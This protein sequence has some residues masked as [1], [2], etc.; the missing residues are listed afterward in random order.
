MA[1]PMVPVGIVAECVAIKSGLI[2]IVQAVKILRC[3]LVVSELF[4]ADLIVSE[5]V[6][7]E[8][9]FQV[10]MRLE[11]VVSVCETVIGKVAGIADCMIV[12]KVVAGETIS[13]DGMAR[14]SMCAKSVSGETVRAKGVTHMDRNMG[15]EAM[16]AVEA[17]PA[18]RRMKAPAKSMKPPA[19]TK[20]MKAAAPSPKSMKPA[21]AAKSVAT[22][23]NCIN[24]RRDA[25][26]ADRN[27]RR[28]NTYC[29]IA[30]LL[31]ARSS[32]IVVRPLVS[33]VRQLPE[34]Y[35]L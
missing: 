10:V 2:E 31:I 16:G 27:A 15:S 11:P 22:T 30:L 3:E 33:A 28:Q 1:A 29:P 14:K 20:S 35:L 32:L 9:L 23:S 34:L 8:I 7:S 18:K 12:T 4:V 19:S 21:P 17:A 13:V 25:K 6:V 5:L 26:R 24:F